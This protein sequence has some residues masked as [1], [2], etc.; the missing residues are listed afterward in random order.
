MTSSRDLISKALI[1]QFNQ[2]DQEVDFLKEQLA[3]LVTTKQELKEN[4]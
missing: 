1:V 3:S 2:Y 4:K